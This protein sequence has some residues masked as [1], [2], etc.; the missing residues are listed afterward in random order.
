[1]R[2]KLMPEH[3]TRRLLLFAYFYPPLGGPAVQRPCKTVK[4]L[5]ELG[6][7][8]DLITTKDI[9]Y[10]STDDSLLAECSHTKV[11]RTPSFD[12]MYLLAFLKKLLGLNT[13]KLYFR[14]SSS[15][16]S[17]IK[18]LFPIDDKIGWL[19]FALQAGRQA[20]LTNRYDAVLVTCGPFSS[21]L[22]ARKTARLGK[23]PFVIDYRDHWTL[24]NTTAQPHGIFFQFLQHLESRILRSADLVLTA[25]DFMKQDLVNRFGQNLSER[26]MTCFNGWD[27][28]DFTGKSRLRQPDGKITISYIGTLYGDRPLAYFL[29]ALHQIMM[30]NPDK[31]V[32][33]QMVG[34]F[35]PETHHE[36]EQSGIADK[37]VFIPQQKHSE[38]I[39]MM[40]DSDIL[41]L[42]IGDDKNR[43]IL[44]GKLFEYLRSQRPILALTSPDS[45]AAQILRSSGH[46]SIC[47]IS[48]TQSI[49]TQL[50]HLLDLLDAGVP[51]YKIP[52]AYERSRQVEN[53]NAALLKLPGLSGWDM[54]YV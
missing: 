40:L 49:R 34:N 42:V 36:I 15:S 38:A 39:Q 30:D 18:K 17:R 53:L 47:D 11:F 27:E 13:G 4:Y 44:T 16:K 9:I 41:L 37:V 28:A 20:L 35:Y 31:S 2:F 19:P 52:N 25:T 8:T 51:D 26:T 5:A 54:N 43:W 14:T 50:Q 22:A 10:H 23:I 21:A 33:L 48:D 24:N 6:W 45:E 7:K 29:S 46:N 1:M 32:E 12:P 3:K